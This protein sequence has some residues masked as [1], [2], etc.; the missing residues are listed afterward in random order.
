MITPGSEASIS[1]RVA[2]GST[3]IALGSG[4]VPVLGTP[5]VV[6]LVEEAAV[7]AVAGSLPDGSTTVGTRITLDH[8][9]PTA[10]GEIVEARASVTTADERT[11][12]FSVVVVEGPTTIARGTHTRAIV[13]K[14]RFLN[15][16]AL[17]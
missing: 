11:V 8:L 4:D 17:S 16:P 7:A 1:F 14:A 12:S 2:D 6:A 15:S 3:A 13:N 9:A 10:V 5:K